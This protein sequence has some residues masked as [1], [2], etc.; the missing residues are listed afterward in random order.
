MFMLQRFEQKSQDSESLPLVPTTKTFLRRFIQAAQASH[1][2]VPDMEMEL[3]L[4]VFFFF[5]EIGELIDQQWLPLQQP[6]IRYLSS[7]LLSFYLPLTKS[8][9]TYI[10]VSKFGSGKA[11]KPLSVA[12]QLATLPIISFEGEKV[13]ETYLDLK[14]APEDTT[15]AVV[16]GRFQF[17]HEGEEDL[18]NFKEP[19]TDFNDKVGK[20]RQRKKDESGLEKTKRKKKRR[21]KILLK[22]P[23]EVQEKWDSITNNENSKDS[24]F[25]RRLHDE[26]R[27]IGRDWKG[28]KGVMGMSLWRS[29]MEVLV[30]MMKTTS[31]QLKT[32]TLRQDFG[33]LVAA[34][35]TSMEQV[36]AGS[37][38]AT[39]ANVPMASPRTQRTISIE[40]PRLPPTPKSPKIHRTTSMVFVNNEI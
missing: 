36:E 7:P 13:G 4:S 40:S 21:S 25:G 18:G 8:L 33:E 27:A 20:K 35:E 37:A 39:A 6:Q 11:S 34:H 24:F 16:Q 5:V 3:K 22:I 38:S 32:L 9:K 30:G 10:S 23:A 29:K 15:R 12:S 19:T 2:V 28:V 14:T 31:L 26:Q 17:N 1:K